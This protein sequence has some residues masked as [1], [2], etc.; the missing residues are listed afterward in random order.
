[1]PKPNFE[2]QNKKIAEIIRVNHA[3]EYGAKR[4]YEG[5][6]RFAKTAE[7]SK[8]IRCMLEQEQKHLDYF[9]KEMI[10]RRVR[11]TILMPAWSCCGYFLGAFSSLLG[12]KAAM[13][14]T[15]AIE[16]VITEH[17]NSQLEDLQ[18][19]T[20]ED[21]LVAKIAQFRSEEAEHQEIAASPQYKRSASSISDIVPNILG[22]VTK[23]I[24]KTAI[25]LS[26]KL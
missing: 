18:S 8:I 10:K 9:T 24:C 6:L 22:R 19:R 12:I 3:G 17:Y 11:P 21:E 7:D 20:N 2:Q 25:Y 26:K 13:Q 14:V 23:H 1:M 5:Q 16:E 15:E 4:I